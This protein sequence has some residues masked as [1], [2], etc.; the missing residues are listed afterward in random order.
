MCDW[1]SI[2]LVLV[3]FNAHTFKILKNDTYR[4]NVIALVEM[5]TAL[6]ANTLLPIQLSEH[7]LTFMSLH[8]R[9]MRVCIFNV[10]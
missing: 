10:C 3:L 8:W 9:D 1:F 5:E 6:H 2:Q 7:K 4:G